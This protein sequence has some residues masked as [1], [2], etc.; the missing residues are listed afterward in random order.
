MTSGGSSPL[1]LGGGALPHG[2]RGS[3]SLTGV[4]GQSPFDLWVRGRIPP[5]AETLLVFGRSME[6]ANLCVFLKFENAKKSENCVIFA[7]KIMGG[8]KTE[9]PEAKLGVCPW[10][11]PETASPP[12]VGT[13]TANNYKNLRIKIICT[14]KF[15]T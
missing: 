8:H 9:G 3:A 15:E 7:K 5:E 2:K 11:R 1:Y 10:P 12:L 4:Q 14:T 13:T 6:A